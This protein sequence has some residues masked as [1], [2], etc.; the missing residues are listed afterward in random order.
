[1]NIIEKNQNQNL[2]EDL[3]KK[4]LLIENKDKSLDNFEQQNNHKKFSVYNFLKWNERDVYEKNYNDIK[5]KYCGISS[6][7][8]KE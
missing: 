4:P 3:L 7:F 5:K 1:M 2:D 8:I 6:L